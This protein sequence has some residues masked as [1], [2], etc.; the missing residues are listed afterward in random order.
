MS[1]VSLIRRP[2]LASFSI[3]ASKSFRRSRLPIPNARYLRLKPRAAGAQEAVRPAEPVRSGAT[4]RTPVHDDVR[5]LR[6]GDD[7]Q[8][9]DREE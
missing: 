8:R 2:T 9:R 7:R 4:G 5:R 3:A 1:Q 6:P